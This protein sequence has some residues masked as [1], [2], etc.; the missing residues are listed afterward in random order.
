L[1]GESPL[2]SIEPVADAGTIESGLA[3]FNDSSFNFLC[4]ACSLIFFS[5]ASSRFLFSAFSA[6]A[7]D[8][9]SAFSFSARAFLSDFSF[10]ERAFLSAFSFSANA[11]LSAFNYSA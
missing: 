10:S 6:S 5:S 9:F 2:C 7:L 4:A 3:T 11:F 8:F 1:D